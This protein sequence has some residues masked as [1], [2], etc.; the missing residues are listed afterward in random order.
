MKQYMKSYG[1]RCYLNGYDVLPIVPGEKRPA[2]RGWSEREITES[3]VREWQNNG[4]ANHGVGIRTGEVV[5]FDVDVPDEALAEE[6]E[7][8]LRRLLGPAP[9]RFGNYPKRGLLYRTKTPFGKL[10]TNEFYGPER[11]QAE[12]LGDGQQF[13]AYATHPETG[14]PYVWLDQDKTPLTTPASELTE[15]AEGQTRAAVE[16]I[17]SCFVLH[18]LTRRQSY[19]PDPPEQSDEDE[20]GQDDRPLGDLTLEKLGKLLEQIPNDDVPYEAGNRDEL[21]WLQVLMAVAHQTGRSSEGRELAY[22]WSS[23]SAK[24]DDAAFDKHWNSLERLRQGRR[25]VT[26]RYLIKLAKRFEEKKRPE[27]LIRAGLFH[28]SASEGEQALRDYGAPLYR[29]GS[30]LVRPVVEE[31]DATEK[32]KTKVARL[33]QITQYSMLDWLSRAAVWRRFDGRSKTKVRINPPMPVVHLLLS[34]EGEWRFPLLRGVITTPTIRSDGSLLIE[35]GYDA[36]TGLLLVAPPALPP[37][38]AHPTKDDALRAVRVLLRLIREFPFVDEASRSV[39]LSIL[40]TPVLRGAIA[41]APMHVASAPAAGTGKTYLIDVASAVATGRLCPVISAGGSN[42]ET[43]KRVG[44]A[45]L[46]GQAIIGIDNVNGEL[47]G[48]QLCQ[49]IS[50]PT[51]QVRILG[52][53]EMPTIENH[54]TIFA[55][56]NN[57]I[58]SSDLVRRTVRAGLDANLERPERRRFEG[59]PVDVVLAER[60]KFVAAVLTIAKAYIDAGAPDQRIEPLVGFAGWDSLVRSALVWLD[61]AD[62]IDTQEDTRDDDPEIVR[63]RDFV[64]A[65]RDAIGVNHP[66][67]A[68]EL[69]E[70]AYESFI[71]DEPAERLHAALSTIAAP[72]RDGR[73]SPRSLGKWLGRQKGRV[74]DGLKIECQRD[75]HNSQFR[76][77]IKFV[78]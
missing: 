55:T 32:R 44:A 41:S 31:V 13:V 33:T 59:D 26:A 22:E 58:I 61:R 71:D 57:I 17:E 69:V 74:I 56:G 28:E 64:L 12:V 21:A 11:H 3:D 43:D 18:G 70:R 76:W 67:T 48:E 15:I 63:L 73:I 37:I 51:V 50:Q 60:G 72:T 5:L 30:G 38:P 4:F 36:P 25:P 20:L 75:G 34:R 77:D 7:I 19:A 23:R 35:P 2:I 54:A 62:P 46:A 29:R 42:E 6:I 52:K 10:A 68:G 66:V 53:S 47:G 45:L 16:W 14:K 49:A 24:H 39:G 1:L 65:W 8:G 40:M 27:I 78:L 9:I